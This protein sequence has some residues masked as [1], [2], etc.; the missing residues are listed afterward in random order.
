MLHLYNG[1]YVTITKKMTKSL[2]IVIEDFPGYFAKGKEWISNNI[3]KMIVFDIF[4][5]LWFIYMYF[6]RY[7]LSDRQD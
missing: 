5:K 4:E 7:I 2:F 6:L 1:F 3:Y